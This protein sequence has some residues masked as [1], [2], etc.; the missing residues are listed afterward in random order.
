VFTLRRILIIGFIC[1]AA[2]FTLGVLALRH[3]LLEQVP[4]V[5]CRLCMAINDHG[6]NVETDEPVDPLVIIGGAGEVCSGGKFGGQT[7]LNIAAKHGDREAASALL[8]A[9]APIELADIFGMTPLMYVVGNWSDGTVRYAK[10]A[11]LLLAHQAACD[12]PADERGWQ[13]I[14]YAAQFRHKD[15]LTFLLMHGAKIDSRAHNGDTPLLLFIE[16][17]NNHNTRGAE[18]AQ[19]MISSGADVK[20]EHD[21]DGLF[22]IHKAASNFNGEIAVAWLID[23]G[24]DVNVLSRDG[25]TPLDIAYEVNSSKPAVISLLVDAGGKRGVSVE[26]GALKQVG[27]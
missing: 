15:A 12:G 2:L 17:W 10:T 21:N 18:I 4:T 22:A 26:A 16:S 3:A 23:N 27:E 25:K 20:N 9:G 13:A 7:P 5:S 14:H 11:E 8:N 6:K 24:A 19:K 1:C